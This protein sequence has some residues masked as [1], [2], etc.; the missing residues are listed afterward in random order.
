MYQ[1]ARGVLDDD[2]YLR[3][4]RGEIRMLNLA[5]ARRSIDPPWPH[6]S[7]DE[8]RQLTAQEEIPG[9]DSLRRAH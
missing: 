3:T 1:A 2:L 6:P 8:Q 9:S 4:V 5:D 7:L